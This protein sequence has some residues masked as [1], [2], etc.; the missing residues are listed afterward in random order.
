MMAS[1]ALI[2]GLIF[3]VVLFSGPLCFVLSKI[4][5]IPTWIVFVLG[6]LTIFI[7][8]WWFLLPIGPIRY[9][10]ILTALLGF[11]SMRAKVNRG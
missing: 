2:V 5:F 1:L 10:G 3:L 8:A 7:G 4:S 9:F 11:Y 6:F